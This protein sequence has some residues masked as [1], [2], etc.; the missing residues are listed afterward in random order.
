M[1]PSSVTQ[2]GTAPHVQ[3]MFMTPSSVTQCG[4]APHVQT[5]FMTHHLLPSAALHLTYRRCS[6]RHHLLPSA[7]LH[8]TY[9]RCSWRHYLDSVHMW[10]LIKTATN[11]TYIPRWLQ[12]TTPNDGVIKYAETCRVWKWLSTLVG[13]CNYKIWVLSELF[14]QYMIIVLTPKPDKAD[15]Y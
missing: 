9:R 15:L 3:T 11:H 12:R 13:N 5:M 10:I 14:P 8:L 2:C 4:T 1:T 6:W 7:A